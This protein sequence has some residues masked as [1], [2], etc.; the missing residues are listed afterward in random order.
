MIPY[1]LHSAILLSGCYLFYR[2]ILTKETFFRMNRWVLIA[3]LILSFTLPGILIPPQWSVWEV[4]KTVPVAESTLPDQALTEPDI[5]EPITPAVSSSEKSLEQLI[6]ATTTEEVLS[7]QDSAVNWWEGLD[8]PLLLGYVYMAGVF[9]FSLNLLI[10]FFVLLF[11]IIRRPSFKDGAYKIVEMKGEQAPFSFA[12]YIFINP[13]RYDLKTF[14]QILAHEKVHIA[15]GHTLDIV[16]AELAVIIQWFNPFAWKFRKAVE[17]NLEYLTD[18]A[19]IRAGTDKE[20][21]QLSLLKVSVPQ[22]ALNLATNYNQSFLKKRILMMNAKKSSARSSWKYLLIVP[23]LAFSMMSMNKVREA[24]IK[25]DSVAVSEQSEPDTYQASEEMAS[26]SSVQTAADLS[27]EKTYKEQVSSMS[28]TGAWDAEIKDNKVCITFVRRKNGSVNMNSHCFERSELGNLPQGREGTFSVKGEAGTIELK[29]EFSGNKGAGS[30]S[31]TESNSFRTYLN[32]EGLRDITEETL[33][34][35]VLTDIGKDYIA[36][37][38]R[39]NYDITDKSLRRLAVH[40]LSMDLIKGY[41]STMNKYGLGKPKVDEL[42]KMKIHNVSPQYFDELSALGFKGLSLETV[43]KSKIH[44]VSADYIRGLKQ[45]GFGNLNMDEVIKFAIHNVDLDY[46]QGMAKAGYDG[47]GAEEVLKAKIHNVDPQFAQE[48]KNI[49][50]NNLKLDEIT[51]MAI[52]NVN[53]SYV[54]KLSEYGYKNLSVDE[55]TKAKIHNVDPEFIKTVREVGYTN[56]TMDEITRFAIHNI[57]G[58]YVK[59]LADAGYANLSAQDLQS[60]KVHGV[61]GQMAS[62][63]AQLG[64]KNIPMQQMINLKIHG[65]TPEYIKKLNDAGVNGLDLEDYKKMK[66]HGTGDKIIRNKKN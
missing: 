50:Y 46:V 33:M 36:Y 10:Q 18:Q 23:L 1:I 40:G 32:G 63:F 17:N 24:E 65:V 21:Y 53:G 49:G 45:A 15:Q 47:M 25:I 19:M 62:G 28:I 8:F 51:K 6:Q 16:L 7:N 61:T 64:F 3:C 5:I 29:G 66:I 35:C 43:V 4:S 31:F 13:S 52:H 22:Y 57:D 38:K 9:I 20:T 54:R 14:Q 34:H 41:T 2:H 12:R 59:G 56:L 58:S 37:L 30:Y 26:S 42:V 39:E 11:Q 60:A 48:L 27:N 44:N 55:I